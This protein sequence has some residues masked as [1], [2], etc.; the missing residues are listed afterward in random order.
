MKKILSAALALL[1]LAGANQ[2]RAQDDKTGA[3]I[4]CF[5]L[6]SVM[7]TA[8]EP[9]IK[10]AGAISAMYWLG[11]LDGTV[12]TEKLEQ[13]VQQRAVDLNTMTQETLTNEVQRCSDIMIE[14][15]AAMVRMSEA[16][17]QSGGNQGAAPVP[18]PQSVR[19]PT[20]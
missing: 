10:N 7:A 1:C 9:E 18:P 11:R 3:D 5:L 2:S 6:M 14:R 16:L 4:R 8:S 19:P 13:L 17:E 12:P 20:R 15:T